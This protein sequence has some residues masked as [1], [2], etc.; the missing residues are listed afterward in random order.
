MSLFLLVFFSIY[1]SMHLLVWYGLRPLLPAHPLTLPLAAGWSV[2]MI[3]AP[4]LSRLCERIGQDSLAR[5]CAWVGYLWLGL[6]FLACSAFAALLLWNGGLAA[7]GRIFP[8]FPLQSLLLIG[9][10]TAASVLLLV[11]GIAVYAGHEA[12]TL[13]VETVTLSVPRLPPALHNLRIVQIS[14]VHLGLILRHAMAAKVGRLISELRPDLVVA[15]GDIVDAQIAHLDGLSEHFRTIT[16]PLG[17]FA[18]T[19][20]HEFY[21]GLIPALAFLKDSGFTVLRN[22]SV[23]VAPGLTMIGIDD[24]S[25]GRSASVTSLLTQEHPEDFILLLKH[26]PRVENPDGHRIDLQ[27]SGHAHRGQIAPFNLMTALQYPL[28]NGLYPTAGGGWLYASRGTGTWGPPLRFFSPP[29][30]TLIILQNS[31]E[32]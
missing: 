12:A 19:G 4:F 17:K 15:T 11:C 1:A 6:L 3:A 9:P 14:D 16:P 5:L 21:A 2:L 13:R 26:R 22:Q 25:G 24:P 10:R 27:L 18:V 8:S 23:R 28:Q 29:E 30:V 32:G 20:N 7:L 31:P